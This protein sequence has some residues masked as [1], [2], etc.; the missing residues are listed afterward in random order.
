[1]KSEFLFCTII[2]LQLVKLSIQIRKK[3]STTKL[4]DFVPVDFSQI[5]KEIRIS[6]Y[7]SNSEIVKSVLDGSYKIQKFKNVTISRLYEN[8]SELDKV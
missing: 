7:C 4:I 8:G 1:M 3:K 6:P 2:T 5:I